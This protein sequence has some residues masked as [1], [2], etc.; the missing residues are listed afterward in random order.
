MI[1]YA[2]LLILNIGC[3]SKTQTN[4][5]TIEAQYTIPQNYVMQLNREVNLKNIQDYTY[6][7]EDSIA[8]NRNITQK[9]TVWQ[10]GID[11][12]HIK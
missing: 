12:G 4:P 6:F 5:I 10:V 2:F 11:R 8:R 7:M 1:I 9:R 3:S